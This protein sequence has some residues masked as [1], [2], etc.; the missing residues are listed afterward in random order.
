MS[1]EMN[2]LINVEGENSFLGWIGH[3]SLPFPS[4]AR[5][6]ETSTTPLP[7]PHTYTHAVLRTATLGAVE[8]G[9]LPATAAEE[10]RQCTVGGA[11]TDGG[12]LRFWRGSSGAGT[13]HKPRSS[14]CLQALL[15]STT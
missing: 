3:L 9:G 4:Q 14:S 13:Y 2:C 5:R 12:A 11:Q 8:L 7:P 6:V 15:V 1:V 10:G